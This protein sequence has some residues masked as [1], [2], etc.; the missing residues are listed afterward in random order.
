[1]LRRRQVRL[2]SAA[3]AAFVYVST[4]LSMKMPRCLPLVP[5]ILR[6]LLLP[7]VSLQQT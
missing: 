5:G 6:T 2:R 7:L 3:M 4:A 1:M